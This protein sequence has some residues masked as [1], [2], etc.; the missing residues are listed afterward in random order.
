MKYYNNGLQLLIMKSNYRFYCV[1][2]ILSPLLCSNY[3]SGTTEATADKTSATEAKQPDV[4][5]EPL[6]CKQE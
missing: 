1:S 2:S 3:N 4:F 5:S 6:K